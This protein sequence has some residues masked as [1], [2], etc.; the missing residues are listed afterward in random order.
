MK[1]SSNLIFRYR[2]ARM[3]GLIVCVAWPLILLLLIMTEKVAPGNFN[4]S[5]LVKEFSYTLTGLTLIGVFFVNYR[6]GKMLSQFKVHSNEEKP[7][8]IFRESL[9]YT[10]VIQM[11]TWYGLLYWLISGWSVSRYVGSFIMLTPICFFLFIPRLSQW[12]SDDD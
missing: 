7:Y 6:S 11:T 3:M 5:D 9:I 1:S 2:I 10:L 8:I 12:E 4:S